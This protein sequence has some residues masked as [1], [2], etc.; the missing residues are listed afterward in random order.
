MTVTGSKKF[1]LDE[2][3]ILI[4]WE[5]TEKRFA[6]RMTVNGKQSEP[7]DFYRKPIVHEGY[8]Y[9]PSYYEGLFSTEVPIKLVA[10]VPV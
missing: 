2:D 4:E 3:E 1:V 9:F 7:N 10:A 8:A 5:D 6:V